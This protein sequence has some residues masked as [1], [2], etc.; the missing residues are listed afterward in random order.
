MEPSPGGQEEEHEAARELWYEE[1]EIVE[2]EEEDELAE[3]D[4]HEHLQR[5]DDIEA[6]AAERERDQSEQARRQRS[7]GPVGR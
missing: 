1:D 4:L 5:C 7:G 6:E 2:E 3:Q